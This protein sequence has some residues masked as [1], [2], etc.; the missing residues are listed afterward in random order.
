[1]GVSAKMMVKPVESANQ[2]ARRR[3]AMVNHQ[4]LFA[5]TSP[6]QSVLVARRAALL[7]NSVMRMTIQTANCARTRRNAM[8]LHLELRAVRHSH[9][10]AW[11]A[12]RA[13]V[14]R[15]SALRTQ[16][17]RCANRFEFLTNSPGANHRT[18][19]IVLSSSE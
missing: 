6:Q 5:V 11:A 13:A 2:H 14:V 16:T 10:H 7:R 17:T 1:M 8:V 15:N 9:L 4:A 18:T 12:P 3:N 19:R